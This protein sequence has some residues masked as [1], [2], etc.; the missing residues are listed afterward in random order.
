MTGLQEQEL[1]KLL[2]R[3]IEL[4]IEQ[5]LRLDELNRKLNKTKKETK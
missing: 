1:F 3:Q 5:N 2:Q 4:L